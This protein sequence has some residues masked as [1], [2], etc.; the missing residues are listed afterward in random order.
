M[1]K[2][3]LVEIIIKKLFFSYKKSIFRGSDRARKIMVLGT[4]NASLETLIN[5]ETIF[6]KT[7]N[8][9]ALF[10]LKKN[11]EIILATIQI[12]IDG[13]HLRLSQT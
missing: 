1:K 4:K 13:R 6:L 2:I 8:F 11:L 9:E 12:T 5:L 3:D 10:E 7:P